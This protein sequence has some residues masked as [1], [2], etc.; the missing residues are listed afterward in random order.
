MN[1]HRGFTFM[2]SFLSFISIILVMVFLPSAATAQE[3]S[4]N[5]LFKEKCAICHSLD[6]ALDRF[7]KTEGWEKVV[8]RERSRAPFW[9]SSEDEYMIRTYLHERDKRIAGGTIGVEM[10]ERAA[11]QKII[12]VEPASS[13]HENVADARFST[14]DAMYAANELLLSG[15]PFFEKITQMG[16]PTDK[17]LIGIT[18]EDAYWFS[19]YILSALAMESGM[20]L[21]IT[22]SQRMI[23]Q[24]EEEGVAVEQI[25]DN[26]LK[27]VSERTG[28]KKPPPGV[29]PI[30]AEFSSGEPVLIELPDFRNYNTL[31]WNPQKFDKTISPAA[32]GLS[33]Y[34]Q[35]LWAE[36]FLGSNHGENLLGNDAVEGYIGSILVAEA[37]SKMHFL[38]AEVAFDGRKLG[39][40]NPFAYEAKL[41]YYPHQ[42]NVE[43]SYPDDAPPKPI[44]YQVGDP[45]SHLFDQASLLLGLSEFYHFSDPKIED[46]WDSV[47]GSSSEGALFP[48][49]PHRTAKGLSGVV[50]KNMI[51]MHFD[52]IRQTFVSEWANGERG[53]DILARDA[54]MALVA[55]ANA[56]ESFHDDDDIRQAARKMLDL[57]AQFLSEYL[58]RDDGG[59]TEGYNIETSAHSEE[60]RALTSQ[61]LAI[62]GLLAAHKI[63]ENQSYQDSALSSMNFMNEV[64][65]SPA[66]KMYRSAEGLDLSSYTPLDIAATLGALREVVLARGDNDAL[67]RFKIVFVSALKNNG[68]QLAELEPT[69]EK[70][71]SVKDVMSPDVDGDGIRKPHFGG[72]KFGVAPVLAGRIQVPTP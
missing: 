67:Q 46:N 49:Q 66:S 58:Q 26:Y 6:K 61:T 56:Y 40:V 33:L 60:P 18:S 19:R 62:R 8:S 9:I 43:L 39:E 59:F 55:L 50:L 69:G 1:N 25:F 20:G 7:D 16:L 65:W 4:G 36:Y 63:T 32:L 11:L 2:A 35:S 27:T 22:Q 54:G 13:L 3:I 47:F 24:A 34:N 72:G 23:L 37:V 17:A 71:S 10:E 5:K 15:V 42:I 28:L 41:M 70:M 44:S 64:L 53:K 21:H 29:Y 45:S 30:F 52:P 12:V 68:M 51:A 48:P 38:K 31:R 57:Q 14:V